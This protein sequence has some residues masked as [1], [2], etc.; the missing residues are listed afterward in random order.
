[1]M[2]RPSA[3]G[4]AHVVAVAATLLLVGGLG[5]WWWSARPQRPDRLPPIA[6]PDTTSDRTVD[7][8]LDLAGRDSSVIRDRWHDEVA[9][10]DLSGLDARRRDLFLR[11]ANAERCTCGCG[12]TLAGCRAT[13]MDCEVSGP[14]LVALRDSVREGWIR[15]AA[16][17]RTRPARGG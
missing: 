14:R 13:D 8:A 7:R 3:G 2:L 15:S 11:F 12:Y 6:T 9:G 17:L 10:I 16:G 1:M 4:R 5:A